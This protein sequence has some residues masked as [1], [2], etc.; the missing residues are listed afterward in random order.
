MEIALD[1]GAEETTFSSVSVALSREL[2]GPA[3]PGFQNC[4]VLISVNVSRVQTESK[5]R[6][7]I[8][9]HSH[10]ILRKQLW[11]RYHRS[12]LFQSQI[13]LHCMTVIGTA[14]REI[15]SII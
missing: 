1:V 10:V 8:G 7:V 2:P 15:F 12:T 6:S 9:T 13:Q 3:V 4:K 11:R 14:F 5:A